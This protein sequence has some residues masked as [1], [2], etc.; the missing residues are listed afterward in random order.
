MQFV[1]ANKCPSIDSFGYQAIVI[2][3]RL[4]R[5]NFFAG[6]IE[7]RKVGGIS[8]GKVIKPGIKFGAHT[9]DVIA[10]TS[11][12]Y[13][14]LLYV[15]YPVSNCVVL[16]LIILLSQRKVSDDTNQNKRYHHG[17]NYGKL[18]TCFIKNIIKIE[19]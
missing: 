14:C 5:D 4:G 8:V 17:K 16:L 3:F 6:N 7:K 1:K 15:G 13:K 18:D 12:A 2:Y 9:I 19:F 11:F 10:K